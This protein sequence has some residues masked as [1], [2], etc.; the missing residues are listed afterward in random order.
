[1]EMP[2]LLKLKHHIYIFYGELHAIF[3]GV[4][5]HGQ[6]HAFLDEILRLE[7]IV[8]QRCRGLFLLLS[9]VAITQEKQT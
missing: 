9:R 6:K 2:T 1:M 4:C 7:Q 8:R 5:L 3:F